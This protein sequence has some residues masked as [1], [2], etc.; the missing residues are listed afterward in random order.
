MNFA[1]LSAGESVF[2]DANVLV[3]HFGPH[4]VLGAASSALVRRIE[5]QELQGLTSTSVLSEVAHHLMGLDD[6]RFFGWRNKVVYRLGQSPGNIQRLSKFRQALE[7]IPQLGIQI[8]S[9]P[10][11]LPGVAA[12]VSQ[13]IGLLSND[14]LIVALMQSNNLTNL[15]SH[16]ADFDRVPGIKRFGPV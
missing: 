7:E 4:P 1:S 12:I 6:S 15:A 10:P 11:D 3:Y 16:D 8:L 14:A 2:L 13:Q 5:N 9:I